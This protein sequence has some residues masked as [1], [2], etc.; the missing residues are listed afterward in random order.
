MKKEVK[1]L[2]RLQLQTVYLLFLKTNTFVVEANYPDE[3]QDSH[4]QRANANLVQS[5]DISQYFMF[6]SGHK[7]R[8]ITVKED[9]LIS[10]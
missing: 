2:I 10:D 1:I 8:K 9:I 3:M 6:K 4:S 5:A 7:K